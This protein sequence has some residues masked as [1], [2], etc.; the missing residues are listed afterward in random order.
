MLE[1]EKKLITESIQS[2]YSKGMVQ[3]SNGNVSM[4][5]EGSGNFLITPSSIPYDRLCKDDLVL[6]NDEL[7][8][9]DGHESPS[10]E[11]FLHREI[12]NSRQDVNAVIHTHS[13]YACAVAVTG[14]SIPPILDEMVVYTG[15]SINVAEYGFPGSEELAQNAV[16]SLGNR[17]AVL[18]KNH[19]L[20]A[21]G[22]DMQDALHVATLAEHAARVF[23]YSRIVGTIQPIPMQSLKIQQEVYCMKSDL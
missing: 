2:L 11:S 6:V 1:K 7:D 20:C 15:G 13:P 5:I 22:Y 10:S 16:K 21:V 12:Y 23:I 4:R 18:L 3:G 14:V 17:K 9:I 8:V 19:G